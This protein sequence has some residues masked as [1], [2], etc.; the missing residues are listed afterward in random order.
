[1]SSRGLIIQR[2]GDAIDEINERGLDMREL[3]PKL[4]SETE[5][6][7]AYLGLPQ[8]LVEMLRPQGV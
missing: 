2:F 7:K 3:S 6:E 8:E 1:M 4:M 5:R